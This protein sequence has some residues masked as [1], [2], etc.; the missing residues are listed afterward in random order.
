MSCLVVWRYLLDI[1][2][3]ESLTESFMYGIVECVDT[4]LLTEVRAMARGRNGRS[5]CSGENLVAFGVEG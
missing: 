5:G 2:F 1:A 3:V 4:G